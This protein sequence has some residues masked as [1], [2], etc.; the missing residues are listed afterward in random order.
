MLYLDAA[1]Q[2]VANPSRVPLTGLPSQAAVE[3]ARATGSD[4]RD[5]DA[6]G[7][8]VRL[9]TLAVA[10][11]DGAGAVAG[12]VQAGFVL[13]LHDQQSARLVLIVT[14]V[15]LAGLIGAAVV[16]FAVTGRALVPVRRTMAAQRRFVADASHELRTPATL[17]RSAAEILEREDLVR[18]E[19]RPFVADI[20]AEAERLGRLVGDLL[21]LASTDAG[22]LKVER[23]A[24]DLADV[25][26][27]TVRRAGVARRRA[28]RD[29]G[30]RGHWTDCDPRR[31]R[32]AR[33]AAA[34]PPRQRLGPLP[35]RRHRPGPGRVVGTHGDARRHRSGSGR[36]R[37]GARARL[38]AVPPA[39]RRAADGGR[40]R[41]RARDRSPAWRPSTTRR[42]R[43]TTPPMAEPGS[44]S[45]SRVRERF[46]IRST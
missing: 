12:F 27:E 24:L 17:I 32:P 21:T 6:G 4:L 18:E 5:V 14:L 9:E 23:G 34:H 11:E 16:A 25:A 10:G 39:A 7:I 30:V 28:R 31:S 42:S 15:G 45:S 19:G 46:H 13:T 29:R 41:A 37:G 36:A 43:S 40:H 8:P 20:G 1:G 2:V 26:S 38:R 3:A 33:P 44:R 35:G 22:V